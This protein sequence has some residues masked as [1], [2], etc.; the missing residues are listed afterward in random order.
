M[1]ASQP[2][3]NRRAGP[4]TPIDRMLAGMQRKPLSRRSFLR[5][6]AIGPAA[7]YLA[8]CSKSV[9]PSRPSASATTPAATG[10]STPPTPVLEGELNIYNWAQ[11][12]NPESLTAFEEEYDVTTTQDFYSSNEDLIARLQAGASGY[13][14]IAPTG[15]AVQ[16]MAEEGL[17]LE[18]DH[19]RIPNIANVDPKYLGLAYDPENRFSL[20]KDWGTT[21]FMYVSDQIG[22]DMTSWADFYA[23]APEFSGKYTVLDSAPEVVGS[24][25]KLHGNSY[26]STDQAEIDEAV[27]LLIELKPHLAGILSSGYREMIQRGESYVALGWNGDYFYTLEDQPSTRY[28]IPSEGTE[29]WVDTWAIPASAPHPNL[30][31][32]F[33]NW[34]LTP[35]RQGTETN[36]TY[37]ASAVTGAAEHTD[38]AIAGDPAIYPPSEVTDKL[39]ANSGD[40]L[41]LQ[42]R[43][44]AWTRFKSA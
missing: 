7:A 19:S 24:A 25:L 27:D 33:I 12:L 26:N 40:P 32:E 10:G 34:I 15:Y 20:P 5:A 38:P 21:G 9:G 35:E 43:T 44:D 11:Y 41:A 8:A 37:Y 30:A 28:V 1:D 39:E 29:F 16:I 18:L 2:R 23:L 3:G 14:L 13:D 17:L 6:A 31:M 22:Q 4:P 42:L 36:F